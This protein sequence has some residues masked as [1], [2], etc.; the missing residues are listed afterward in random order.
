M[1]AATTSPLGIDFTKQ[2]VQ[3]LLDAVDA[4]TKTAY[5][6][7]WTDINQ[8]LIEHWLIVTFF[9]IVLLLVAVARYFIT[10]RW[11]MLGS[12]LYN[13]LYF[14]VLLIIA[15]AFGSDVFASDYFKIVLVVLYIV[16]FTIVGIFLKKTGIRQLH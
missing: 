9:L 13:Y 2:I 16:C 1:N 15:L 4:G 10:G 14:G 6:W 5:H 11:A 12:V 3:G 8:L 7:I